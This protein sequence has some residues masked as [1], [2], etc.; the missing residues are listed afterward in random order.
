MPDANVVVKQLD[1]ADL[2]TVKKFA[3]EIL[4]SE[5]SIDYLVLNAAVMA[6][7][8]VSALFVNFRTVHGSDGCYNGLLLLAV[9]AMP[10]DNEAG[11]RD[12]DRHQSLWALLP[13]QVSYLGSIPVCIA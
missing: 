4:S 8:K 5:R 11:F 1:L 13:H 12:A 9:S 10:V 2:V 7:P 3:D 6:C